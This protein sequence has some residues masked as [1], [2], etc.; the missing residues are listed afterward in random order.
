MLKLVARRVLSS[1]ILVLLLVT[2]VFFIVR[3]APGDPLDLMV[4]EDMGPAEREAVAHR[5]GLD[6]SL[7]QQYR[8]WLRDLARGDAGFSLTRHQ[9]VREILAETLPVTLLLTVT[10][11]TLHLL[12][13][14]AAAVFM[15]TRRGRFS[16]QF[17]QGV[18]LFCYSVPP[19][20]LGLMLIMIFA[21]GLGW[22]PTSGMHAPDA[23][24]MGGWARFGDLLRH[25]VL[26]VTTL[27]LSMFMGTARYLRG[28]L[29]EI[30]RQDYILAARARGVP[31]RRILWRHALPNALLPLITLLGLH[32]PFLLGGAMVVEVVFGWPGM[33]TLTV[34]AIGQ[35]DYPVIMLTTLVAALAVVAGGLLADLLYTW[36]DPRVRLTGRREG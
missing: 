12:L 17:L 9:P 4:S 2:A 34:D 15:I 27:A 19:F 29:E 22:L 28:S 18:G 1:L 24:F 10:S 33:G 14:V 5:Y 32:L 31:A 3:L 21:A 30:L 13:A 20:W 7:P 23:A 36:A 25:M 8:I 26:P 11:Y 16:A 35:R 6:R